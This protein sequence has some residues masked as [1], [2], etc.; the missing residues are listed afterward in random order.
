MWIQIKTQG[1]LEES[2]TKYVKCWWKKFNIQK[3][4]FFQEK[5][6]VCPKSNSNFIK[7]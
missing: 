4:K 7:V 3:N 2:P 1:F 6:P 5:F